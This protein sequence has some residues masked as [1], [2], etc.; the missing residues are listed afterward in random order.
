MYCHRYLFLPV[1]WIFRYHSAQLDPGWQSK[2]LFERTRL[3]LK[4]GMRLWACDCGL[5]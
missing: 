3:I 4:M 1:H 5:G 2:R